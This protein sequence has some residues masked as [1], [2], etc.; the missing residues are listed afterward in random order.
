MSLSSLSS[1]IQKVCVCHPL[2]GRGHKLHVCVDDLVWVHVG[3]LD[4]LPDLALQTLGPSPGDGELDGLRVPP[5][6]RML[7]TFFVVF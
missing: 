1:I 3:Q 2:N 5:V 7:V 4:G 6:L